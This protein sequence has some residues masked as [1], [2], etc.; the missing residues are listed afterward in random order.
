MQNSKVIAYALRIR[1]GPGTNYPTLGYL[2]QNDVVEVFGTNTDGS[3]SQ[4]KSQSGQEGWVSSVYL[5]AS[6]SSSTHPEE[7]PVEGTQ[8]RV[9]ATALY[10]RSG[11]GNNYPAITY[12]KQDEVVEGLEAPVGDWVKIRRDNGLAGWCHTKFLLVLGESSTEPNTGS[13]PLFRVIAYAL[14]LRSGPGSNYQVSGYLRQ[15]DIVHGLDYSPDRNWLKIRKTDGETAWCA[16]KYLLQISEPPPPE[17]QLDDLEKIGLHRVT[18][19]ALNIHKTPDE[20]EEII[21]TLEFEQIVDVLSISADKLWKEVVTAEGKLGWCD[22]YYL[23]HIGEL[24][25]LKADEEFPWMP[26][27]FKEL[28]IREFPGAPNNPRI[29]EYLNSTTLNKLPYD[30]P[31]ETDWCAAFINWCVE[32][33]G[34]EGNKSALV[35]PWTKWGKP[36][37]SPRR[38]CIV[39]FRWDDGGTHVSFYV[40][41]KNGRTYALGGNQSDAVWIKSYLTQY[42]TGYRVPENWLP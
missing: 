38:G 23:D 6:A 32:E 40:G 35:Y 4:I 28:G 29:L 1:K 37:S 36:L 21:G 27:A 24:G 22:I 2:R 13:E 17:K 9:T 11:P 12:L 5:K 42:V 14:Y 18:L 10:V 31:D 7:E 26:F 39:T 30:L 8:Y 20:S 25:E 33:S 15:G 41:E 19:K 3:W 16:K 34:Q